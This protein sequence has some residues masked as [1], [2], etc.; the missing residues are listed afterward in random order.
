LTAEVRSSDTTV[1]AGE[2]EHAAGRLGWQLDSELGEDVGSRW[3]ELELSF[4][5]SAFKRT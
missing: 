5:V 2:G 3:A 1:D 4:T